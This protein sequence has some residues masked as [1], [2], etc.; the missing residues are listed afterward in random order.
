MHTIRRVDGSI[1]PTQ[2][3]DR[4]RLRSTRLA[5][6][7]SAALLAVGCAP[8]AIDAP[9]VTDGLDLAG[10]ADAKFISV[11]NPIPDRYIVVLADRDVRR[12][13]AIAPLARDVAEAY[14]AELVH[15]YEHTVAGFAAEMTE[16]DAR[17][18]AADARVAYVE[19]DSIVSISAS[20]SGATWGLDRIDQRDRPLNGTYS[21]EATGAGVPVYVIDTGIRVSHSNFGGRAQPG[22]SAINDGRGS[23]DCNGH[24]THVAGTVGANTWGVAKGSTLVAVRVLGCNGSGSNSGVIAGV[25]WVAARGGPAVA[26]MSLGGGSSTALDNA[27]RN[28]VSKGVVMV[29]AAGNENRD[30]CTGSPARVSEAITVGSST[31]SD[32]RSSFSNFGSCVDLFAPG[33]NI[34]STWH[35]NDGATNTISGTSMA[36]PHVAGAAALYLHANP[37]ATPAQI[38]AALVGNASTGKLTSV[39]SGSP[40][41]L[42]FTGFIGGGS[43]GGGGGGGGGGDPQ[44]PPPSGGT[45]KSGSASG[46]LTQGQARSY[47]GLSVR[48]GSTFRAQLTGTGDADLYVRWNDQPTLSQWHCRPYREGSGETCEMTVPAGATTAHIMVHGYS[49]ATYTLTVSWIE[50]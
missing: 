38:G 50:P 8:D 39:G 15:T 16:E 20:Q 44:P 10:E 13:A 9:P 29:V 48:T 11:D 14:A 23:D 47:Q 5:G 45:A 43:G 25:D 24:G 2:P 34:A 33:S 22:F 4:I 31:S 7:L 6:A 21:W 12:R 32:A 30:A 36:S 3:H 26:N 41:R 1:L 35:T 37:G 18:L 40:N 19:Q 49:A 46:S 28:A 17:A 27:V 42:L